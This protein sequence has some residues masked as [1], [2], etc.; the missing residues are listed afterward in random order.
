MGQ[1][2]RTVAAHAGRRGARGRL[3]ARP[4]SSRPSPA[5][6]YGDM[7]TGGSTSIRAHVRAAAQGRRAAREMLV[8]AAAR[9]WK[10]DPRRVPRRRT[11]RSSTRPE[12]PPA[13]L[14]GARRGAPRRL[15]V[16]AEADAQ[17]PEGP[18]RCIGT[19]AA[20]PRRARPRWT[21]APCS[22]ID[23]RVPGMLTACVV[24]LPGVRRQGRAVR[25][26][27]GRCA[28]P[29]VVHVV[30]RRERRRRRRRLVPGPRSA[31]AEALARDLGRGPARR[32]STAPRIA[33]DLRRAGPQAGRGASARTATAPRRSPGPRARSRPCTRCRTSRTRRWSR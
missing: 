8:A 32:R 18:A 21:A 14:R 12:R 28:V 33:Q 5:P 1:G 25:S 11:A 13:R 27:R 29:G 10:V 20:A 9:E 22:A 16:P 23:V 2:V 7:S 26:A 17:G 15:P 6:K 4:R 30:P 24:A 19:H 31:G 3:A